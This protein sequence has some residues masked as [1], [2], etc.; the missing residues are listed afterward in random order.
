MVCTEEKLNFDT[1]STGDTSDVHGLFHFSD[2]LLGAESPASP[3]PGQADVSTDIFDNFPSEDSK[4]EEPVV[5]IGP[6]SEKGVQISVYQSCIDGVCKCKYE[7]GDRYTQLKPCRFTYLC[8]GD[9]RVPCI[10][11]LKMYNGILDGFKITDSDLV[12]YECENY[13]SVLNDE[14]K[15]KM[16]AIIRDELR[17]GYMSVVDEKPRCVHALRAVPKPGG[18]N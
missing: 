1:H 15:P 8:F 4:D 16:D 14:N 17:L 5:F 12:G 10:D 13:S 9:N 7:L 18:G 6:P 3:K 2:S 11:E